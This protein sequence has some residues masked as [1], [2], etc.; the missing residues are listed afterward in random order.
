MRTPALV[1]GGGI[2]GAALAAHLAQAGRSVLL[3]ERRDGAHHKVCG[4]FVSGEAALYLR[5]LEID[6]AAL[7]AVRMRA[8]RVCAGRRV[9]IAPLPFPAFSISR[10]LLDEALLR[11]AADSGAEIRRRTGA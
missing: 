6:L 4:E 9:A 5:D 2:A 3:I 10:R 8:V 1:I 7:G 11:T